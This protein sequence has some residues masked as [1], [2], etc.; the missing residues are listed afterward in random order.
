MKK[1]EPFAPRLSLKLI[2]NSRLDYLMIRR[3]LINGTISLLMIFVFPL[4]SMAADQ[5]TSG[6]DSSVAGTAQAPAT[7]NL[8]DQSQ[9]TNNSS[10]DNQSNQPVGSIPQGPTGPDANTY[11]YN[12]S[13]GLW[14]NQY[15]TWDPTT[16]KST[17]KNPPTYSYNPATGMWDTTQWVYDPLAGKYVPNVISSSPMAPDGM[18]APVAAAATALASNTGAGSNNTT[19]SSTTNNGYF[20]NFYN[21]A[22]SNQVNSNA[23]SGNALV[24]NN[25]V[26][27]SALSGNALDVS[28]IIN[29]LQSQWNLQSAANLLTFTDNI[30]GDVTGDI[31]INLTPAANTGPLSTNTSNS[32]TDNNL[33]INNKG[34]GLITNDINIGATSGS[35]TVANNTNAGSALSGNANAVANVVNVLNTAISAGQSFLGVVNIN[36]NLNGDILLPP[37]FVNQLIASGAPSSTINLSQIKNNNVVAD[38]TGTQTINNNVNLT[39]AS[40]SATVANNTNAGNA[41]SGNASTNLTIFNLTGNQVIAKNSL[42]VFV[43]VLGQWVGLIMNAPA[44]STTAALCGGTCQTSTIT[45]SNVTLT[46]DSHNTINN[47]LSVSSKSG[48]AVVANNTN[49]GS[50]TTGNATASANLINMSGD[51]FSLSDWFGI[52]FINVL[53]T[54]HGSFGINT[55]AGNLPAGSGGGEALGFNSGFHAPASSGSSAK[56]FVFGFIPNQD[57]GF[58]AADYG[59]TTSNSGNDS[60][61]QNNHKTTPQVLGAS[62][63]NPNPPTPTSGSGDGS[64]SWVIPA[65]GLGVFGLSF[66][67]GYIEE[68]SNKFSV[69]FLS[70]KL[71]RH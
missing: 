47:N 13:T 8:T 43:N 17:P 20:G 11:T 62:T 70:Y 45:S 39:A 1:G 48:D 50:A 14:E 52:L 33:T 27:G 32:Q 40:G 28:N 30:N 10:T 31:T 51:N 67:V 29:M 37:D 54:W 59:A 22:I 2:L 71:R 35:A 46:S 44:G 34:S 58:S 3:L 66:A 4:N 26:A 15:Y 68:L 19:N 69:A 7:D 36:G 16:G 12:Q 49:A 55:D 64:I 57:G 65:V 53:G 63:D 25:T 38:S 24:V 6:A 21:A 60:S 23:V 18:S 5:S 42:L 61:S 56:V 9:T 41:T